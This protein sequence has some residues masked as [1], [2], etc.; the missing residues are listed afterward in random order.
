MT[1][2]NKTVLLLGF[3][4]STASGAP[5]TFTNDMLLGMIKGESQRCATAGYDLDHFLLDPTNPDI[6]SLKDKL[7]QQSWDVVSI[8]FGVR[9]SHGW[10]GLFET[11]VNTVVEEAKPV[12]KFAFNLMPNQVVEAVQRVLSADGSA[13]AT[14]VKAGQYIVET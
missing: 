1:T 12:P 10:T 4:A 13:G 2:T 14:E 8:G 3:E 7:R 6:A 5:P 11:M 9:G